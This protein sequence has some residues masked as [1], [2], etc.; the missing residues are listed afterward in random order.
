MFGLQKFGDG[1]AFDRIDRFCAAEG[2]DRTELARV[3]IAVT[4]SNGKGSTARFM[5]FA[6]RGLGLR[7]GCFTSPHLFDVRERF[8]IDGAMIDAATF[9]RLAARVKAFADHL[10]PGDRMGAFEFLFLVAVLWFTET[11]CDVIV[12]EAGIGGRY[13]PIRATGAGVSAMTSIEREHTE[14]LGQQEDMIACDKCDALA[15]GGVLVISPSIREDIVCAVTA[16]AALS[17]RRVL[18]PRAQGEDLQNTAEGASLTWR[19][20]DDTRVR[21]PLIGR[22]QVDNAVTAIGAAS[23]WL[24]RD[25]ARPQPRGGVRARMLAALAETQW[26]GRLQHV[27]TAPDLWIDVGHTPHALDI[28]T[29]TFAD[30]APRERTLVVFG[31]SAAKDVAAIADIVAQ[32]FDHII[33]TRAFKSGAEPAAFSDRFASHDV[34]LTHDTVEAARI[35]RARAA[36]EGFTVLAIGGLFLAVEIAHAWTGGD[37]RELA[38]L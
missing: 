12:W 10:P 11:G 33:L 4:G 28:V 7:T 38:F 14:L 21:L 25:P 35:A 27:A 26:P 8:D 36:A 19:G 1:I 16:Y 18:R 31:V 17:Q 20:E 9:D 22:H 29:E 15:P 24:A 23:A 34:L 30:I 6:L 2:V 13:D 5:A 32:R 37:P 3:S